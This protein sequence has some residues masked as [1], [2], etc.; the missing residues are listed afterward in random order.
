[1]K[2]YGSKCDVII[3]V[4]KSASWVKLCVY[5]LLKNTSAD[6]LGKVF[7]IN[8]CDDEFTTNCLKNLKAKYGKR[9]EVLQNEKNLGFIGTTNRGIE[10]SSADFVLLLNSDCLISKNTIEKLMQNMKQDEKIGLMCPLASNAAN[11]SLPVPAGYTYT[12]VNEVLEREFAG[13]IFDACTVVGNCLMISR[14][15]IE[16]VGLLDKAYG[17]GYGEET[18]YQFKAM[19][20]GFS[21]KVAIDT[22]V[23]HKSE[24]SFGTSQEKQERLNK[25]RELFFSRWGEQY[26]KELEK[27]RLNDPIEYVKKHLDF[28]EKKNSI[29]TVFLIDG[30]VQN[31]GGVHVVVDIVNYLAINGYAANIAYNLKYPYKEAMLFEP[32][33]AKHIDDYDVK[34]LVSTVWKTAYD[35]RGVAD[36]KSIPLISF[37]QGYEGYFD[38]GSAYGGVETSYKLADSYLTIS[39]YLKNTIEETFDIKTSKITNGINLDLLLNNDCR[40]NVA[41][42][43]TIILRGSIMKGDFILIDVVKKMT[44]KCKDI[45]I[46]LI[47]PIN[48]N[49][50]PSFGNKNNVEVNYLKGPLDRETIYHL[51]QESDIYVDASLNEGFGLTALEAM[52]AGAVPV[53]SASFGINEYAKNG[54]N[55]LVIDKVN[56]A[57]EYVTKIQELLNNKRLFNSCRKNA[58]KTSE[59]FDFDNTAEQYIK[60]F[61]T[62][63]EQ[64]SQRRELD[65]HDMVFVDKLSSDRKSHNKKST[66]LKVASK[67]LPRGVK[68]RIIEAVN[69]IHDYY[70]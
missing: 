69:K 45:K 19:A 54:V 47:S 29:D 42:T 59:K 41:K 55:S 35:A 67:V 49:N 21:A 57:D 65:E 25:N 66:A 70:N 53:M 64:K 2:N 18:D 4:Y 3:P 44:Q 11:I 12:Q 43:V 52:A 10:A 16:E 56:D 23:F 30:I 39:D 46:N 1:M 40:E 28:K 68:T 50:L 51:L 37:L 26:K 33:E 15:C 6:A 48:S 5:A 60:F 31:A 24:A 22:Y 61:E 9:I 32:F 62:A 34:Q 14:K 63:T 7:L 38:G 58:L 17:T 8:D 13:K 27:Y 36:K 20:K